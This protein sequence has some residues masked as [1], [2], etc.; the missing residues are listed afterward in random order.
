[1]AYKYPYNDE[2]KKYQHPKLQTNRNM[3]KLM[4]L[5][6]LTLGIYSIY[7][8]SPFDYE[9]EKIAPTREKNKLMP[10]GVA[11]LVA[12]FT[13][14]IVM[15]FWQHELAK[16]IEDALT[17]RGITTD[18]STNDFWGWY[19]FG[20]LTVVGPYIYFHKLCKA[21]NLLCEDYNKNLTAKN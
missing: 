5:S 12:Y 18:F 21:M 8:F 20:S 11:Y 19:F 14:A 16:R 2:N 15:V 13:F 4:I 7:F 9:L 17:A 3:W 1:M 10:Y 6:V